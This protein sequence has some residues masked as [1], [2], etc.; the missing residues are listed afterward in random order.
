MHKATTAPDGSLWS[1]KGE[2]LSTEDINN[3]ILVL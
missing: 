2:D 3:M 1:S